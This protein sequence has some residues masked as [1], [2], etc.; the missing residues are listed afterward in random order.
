MAPR[1]GPVGQGLHAVKRWTYRD[2]RPGRLARA[3]N[4][5]SA[6]QFSAGVLSP[7]RAVTL[8]LRGR[9]SGRTIAFPVVVADFEGGR[10]LVS[11]LGEKANWVR[12]LRAADGRAILR[13]GRRKPVQLV[14]VEPADR[15]PILRRYLALAPGARPHVPVD[16]RAPLAAFERIAAD[17]PVFRIVE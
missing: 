3:M 2:N 15:A 17:Y 5:L 10:Y 8:E 9:R 14:E 12:N 1:L 11:M 7:R 4:W 13:R 6:V 16:R